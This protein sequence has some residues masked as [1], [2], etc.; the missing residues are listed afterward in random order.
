M[1][2]K[3][4]IVAALLR[5]YPSAWRSEYEPELTDILLARPLSARAT[6][7]VVWSGLR[8]RALAAEPST[9]LGFAALLII[10]GRFVL[11]GVTYGHDGTA[12]LQPSS[13]RFPTVTVTFLSSAY[14]A[15]LLLGCGCWTYLRYG[16]TAKQ[17]GMAA[18]RMSLIAG[19]PIIVGALLMMAGLLG[20]SVSAP[21]LHPPS[22]WSIL[23]VPLA[24]LPGAWMWGALGGQLGKWIVRRRKHAA[25]AS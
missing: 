7:D 2:M 18:M 22:A 8:Q 12:L 6:G 4:W 16:R 19:M 25:A 1:T 17:S 20:V 23:V 10:L 5:L 21:R 24:R 14:Y 11:V 3:Q 9:I 15:Y 13:I